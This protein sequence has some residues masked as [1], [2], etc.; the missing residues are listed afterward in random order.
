MA[1]P[2]PAILI[3]IDIGTSAV[4][5]GA[6]EWH[7]Q[8]L[9]TARAPYPTVYG[10][11]GAEQSA[12]DW[13]QAVATVLRGVSGGVDAARIAAIAVGGHAPSPVFVDSKMRPI[14]PV[15]T[16]LDRRPMAFARAVA[17]ELGRPPRGASERLTVAL[18]ARAL[19]MRSMSR[20]LLSSASCILHSW[21]FVIAQFT[22]RRVATNAQHP[23]LFQLMGMPPSLLPQEECL[24]GTVA[25]ALSSSAAIA[26]GLPSGLPIVVGGLDS[27]LAALG[28]GIAQPGDVC[29]NGGSSS[30]LAMIAPNGVEGRFKI[31]GHPVLS[32]PVSQSGMAI[33]L[34]ERIAGASSTVLLQ[35]TLEQIN[36]L[37]PIDPAA[38]LDVDETSTIPEFEKLASRHGGA[39]VLRAVVDGAL[40]LER[41]ALRRYGRIAGS[42]ESIRMVGGQAA[43]K[44]LRVLRAGAFASDLAIPEVIDSGTLGGAILGATACGLVGDY[45]ATVASMV[46]IAH[47]ERPI[48]AVI[49]SY[50]RLSA[51]AERT[52]I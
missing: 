1:P 48:P 15:M 11:G 27:F 51:D 38:L 29:L 6:W 20:S 5:C 10:S 24:P 50:A 33:G 13:C 49:A 2:K 45:Q 43:A 7:R 21:E 32:E 18:L 3:G 35:S 39:A 47:I 12:E 9:G 16:W 36:C 31:G 17:T 26:L 34:A 19:Y 46:R 41:D 25:G 23:E 52:R 40:L 28:S 4:K 44:S 8:C 37:P 30:V 14:A 42:V 22:G